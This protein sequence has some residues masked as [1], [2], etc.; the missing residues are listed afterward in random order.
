MTTVSGDWLTTPGTQAV[1]A[2]LENAGHQAYAVGGCVRN[3]LLGEPVADVDI[4]T[5]ARPET[6][7]ELARTAGLKPVPTGL[8]HGT[9]TVVAGRQGYEVTTF[10]ADVETDG[11]RAVVSFSDDI[12]A[13]AVRRD[14][15]MNALY[16]DKDGHV[17]DP[18]GGLPDL[19]A[20]RVRFIEDADRRI[21]EDYLRSLRYF[22]FFA[23]YGDPADG[24]DPDAMS[25]IS[26]NL[27]GLDLLSRERVGQELVK[28]FGAPD[29][30]PAACIMARTGVL[31]K[32]LPGA[33]E[34]PLGPL[35]VHEQSLM[36][37]PEPLRRLAVMGVSDGRSLR[38]SKPKQKRLA[39]YQDL[40]G[41]TQS[42][43][44]IAYRHGVDIALDVLAARAASFE[45][46]LPQ[47]DRQ[48]LEH[49]ANARF[50]LRGK[51]LQTAYQG[52][53]LGDALKRLERNWIDS[54]FTLAK[55]ALLAQL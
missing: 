1:F 41:V 47:I 23:W 7:M 36:L 55:A 20:R 18:L 45:T 15:T 19:R 10:R 17:L 14:F 2:M 39:L 27:D 53:A 11:R 31:A 48:A 5:S 12:H 9:I 49:A 28:L 32:V 26:S 6:V 40:I 52:K 25:A 35:L 33:T 43:I 30:Y 16:A 8:E 42:P 24:V 37:P 34:V 46:P 29:P 50:P 51:D 3:A 4:S 44:E 54:G 22:R 38:L 21:R 13:D